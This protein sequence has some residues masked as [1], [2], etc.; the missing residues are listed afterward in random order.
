MAV[1][2]CEED[3]V[4]EVDRDAVRRRRHAVVDVIRRRHLDTDSVSVVQVK[5]RQL[6]G[7]G[8]R[9]DTALTADQRLRGDTV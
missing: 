8:G 7:A 2:Q 5:A 9:R 3:G 4:S 6:H 1:D